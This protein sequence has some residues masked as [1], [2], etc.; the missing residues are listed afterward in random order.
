MSDADE[1][2]KKLEGTDLEK[3]LKALRPGDDVGMH[4]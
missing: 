1:S 3:S 2:L 4:R